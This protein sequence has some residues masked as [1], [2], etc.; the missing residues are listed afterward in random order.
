MRGT[1]SGASDTGTS[2]TS[3]RRQTPAT[4][5]GKGSYGAALRLH[6]ASASAAKIAQR[7]VI[8]FDSHMPPGSA[9]LPCSFMAKFKPVRPKSK[10]APVPQGAVSCV[11]MVIAGMVLVMVFLY[12]VM[13]TSG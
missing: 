9:V 8:C 2:R 3:V 1:G 7:R 6:A 11:I 10:K 13:R 12:F 4:V 5:S